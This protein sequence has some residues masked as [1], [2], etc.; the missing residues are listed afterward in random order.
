VKRTASGSP[1]QQF[2][3]SR[4]HT[5]S[6]WGIFS[7][8]TCTVRNRS[9][10]R[11]SGKARRKFTL[12]SSAALCSKAATRFPYPNHGRSAGPPKNSS[13]SRQAGWTLSEGK[14]AANA[15]VYY[16]QRKGRVNGRL[17]FCLSAGY[18]I[19]LTTLINP[20]REI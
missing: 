8:L 1:W 17:W 5:S 20:V 6:T 13:K 7:P 11:P 4:F 16:V 15:E 19:R 18:T 3:Q 12:L 14:P 10:K 9:S 2:S